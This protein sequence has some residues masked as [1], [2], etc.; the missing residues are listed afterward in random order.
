MCLMKIPAAAPIFDFCPPPRAGLP[1]DLAGSLVSFLPPPPPPT[2]LS[3]VNDKG[4]R[5]AR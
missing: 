3:I 1:L 5:A 2:A 4:E